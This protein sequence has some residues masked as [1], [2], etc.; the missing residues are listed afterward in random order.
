MLVVVVDVVRG[1]VVDVVANTWG[2]P[3]T[4]IGGSVLVKEIAVKR[5]RA[6]V[7]TTNAKSLIFDLWKPNPKLASIKPQNDPRIP[8]NAPH[9]VSNSTDM[10][11]ER[12]NRQ[13]ANPMAPPN[14]PPTA[15]EFRPL[16]FRSS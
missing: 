11:P 13:W 3:F 7:E 9:A 6:K 2:A 4:R 1:L 8:P 15:I 10:W 16:I 14:V 5:T 12:L